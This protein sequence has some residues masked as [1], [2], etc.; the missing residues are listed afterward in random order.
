MNIIAEIKELGN[1]IREEAP[2]YMHVDLQ[3]R[4]E[5]IGVTLI[6]GCSHNDRVYL[7]PYS[8]FDEDLKASNAISKRIADFVDD[9]NNKRYDF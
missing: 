9:I 7:V 5:G 6:V 2:E 8:Y 4:N 3:I 1:T